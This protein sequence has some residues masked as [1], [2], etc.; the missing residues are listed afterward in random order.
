MTIRTFEHFPQQSK[1]FLCGKNDD[2]E[3]TLIGVDGTADDGIEEAL[4][5]HTSCLMDKDN[6][7][8][9]KNMGVIYGRES[10]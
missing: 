6:W 8:I 1:C 10:E 2:S 4:P 7:R 5:I 3:C 9:N